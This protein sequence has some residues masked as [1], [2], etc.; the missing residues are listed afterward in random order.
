MSRNVSYR[1]VVEVTAAVWLDAEQGEEERDLVTRR[2]DDSYF[3][4]HVHRVVARPARTHYATAGRRQHLVTRC[5]Q[6]T[7]PNTL[8]ITSSSSSSGILVWP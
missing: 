6:H 1:Q 8:Q 2:S 3:T 5:T 4:V 7:Q